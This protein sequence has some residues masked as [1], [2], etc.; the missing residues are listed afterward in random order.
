MAPRLHGG[1]EGENWDTKVIKASDAHRC[2]E[3]SVLSV[4]NMILQAADQVY[5]H[6]RSQGSSI[7]TWPEVTFVTTLLRLLAQKIQRR[8]SGLCRDCLSKKILQQENSRKTRTVRYYERVRK[9][10]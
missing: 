7:F 8:S 6:W 10:K 2:C 5:E 9:E 1:N 4:A 3:N